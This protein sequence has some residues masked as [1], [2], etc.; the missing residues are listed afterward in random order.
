MQKYQT[1]VVKGKLSWKVKLSM[2]QLI[3][4]PALTYGHELFGELASY[5]ALY[6]SLV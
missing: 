5:Q 6:V 2:Y 4:V 1:V 3:Y